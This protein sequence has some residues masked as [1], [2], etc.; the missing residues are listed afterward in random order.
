MNLCAA[1]SWVSSMVT[2]VMFICSLVA[3][4][5]C[6][7][8]IALSTLRCSSFD[9]GAAVPCSNSSSDTSSKRNNMLGCTAGTVTSLPPFGRAGSSGMVGILSWWVLL[10]LLLLSF[11]L[12]SAFA[13]AS[14]S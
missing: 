11:F 3:N 14:A 4:F 6:T 9:K 5:C 7:S 13:P 2:I 10:L 8:A 12:W 1:T